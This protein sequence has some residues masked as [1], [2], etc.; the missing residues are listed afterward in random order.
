MKHPSISSSARL[1]ALGVALS[2]FASA[3]VVS[4]N[5]DRFGTVAPTNVAGVE[6]V[7]NWNNSW[8]S[9]PTTDL[10]DNTG[11]ATTLDLA[12]TSFG[13]WTVNEPSP[14]NPGMDADGTFNR[15]LLN[16]YLNSGNAAWGPSITHS[17]ISF[18]QIP[19][20]QYSVI[21]YFSSDAAGREGDVTDGTSTYSFNTVGIASVSGVNALL[22]QT[23]DTGG[24]Y[25]TTANYAI[26]AG[27]SGAAQTFTV[28]MRDNDEWGGIAGIQL[29]S[30]PEPS[31]AAALV[32][33]AGLAFA[34]IRR[35]RRA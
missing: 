30:V 23:T 7:S 33:V 29:V 18:T 34:S 3:S 9:N 8:P 19:Y 22:A 10:V 35:R 14:A 2:S 4:W 21:V 12:Y 5:L 13:Q 27:L 6:P 24:T 15:N 32:G 1:F 28:Q 17:R 26:F 16:G 11:A 20:A 25:G 31:S